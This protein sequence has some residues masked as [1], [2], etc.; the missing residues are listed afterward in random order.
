VQ[1]EV[2]SVCI[3]NPSFVKVLFKLSYLIAKTT[4]S[5]FIWTNFLT[6]FS[7]GGDYYLFRPVYGRRRKTNTEQ[8]S[9]VG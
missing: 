8:E 5:E 4:Y 2:R 9:H 7:V 1:L 3:P 6:L